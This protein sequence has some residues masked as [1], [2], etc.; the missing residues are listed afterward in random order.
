M[1]LIQC[2][3]R[4]LEQETTLILQAGPTSPHQVRKDGNLLHIQ[5]FLIAL[6]RSS[7]LHLNPIDALRE[8]TL[9]DVR[10]LACVGME[11]GIALRESRAVDGNED[12]IWPTH[13]QLFG[14]GW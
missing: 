4:T 2:L 5:P 10:T 6:F 14:D 11:L 3:H 9:V 7:N 12:L 13:G 1:H 8:A